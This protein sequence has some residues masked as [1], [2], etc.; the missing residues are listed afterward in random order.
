MSGYENGHIEMDVD[1]SDHASDKGPV[2]ENE[3]ASVAVTLDTEGNSPRL[4]LDDLRGGRVRY[5]DALE[6]ETIIWI[7]DDH[8]RELMDPSDQRW[9]E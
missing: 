3:F 5:L 4:R 1:P 6:L 7:S 8:L 2:V 9:R